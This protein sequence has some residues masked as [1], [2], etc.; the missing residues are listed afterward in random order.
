MLP[1]HFD[2]GTRILHTADKA[3]GY[4]QQLTHFSGQLTWGAVGWK[5]MP[6]ISEPVLEGDL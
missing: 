3:Q 6:F 5:A 1:R 2:E 4:T